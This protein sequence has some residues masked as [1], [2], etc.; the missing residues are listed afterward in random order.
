MCAVL[1][2]QLVVFLFFFLLAASIG[3]ALL[4]IV[5]YVPHNK[6]SLK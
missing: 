1:L 5:R 3:N 6:I 2:V 4:L